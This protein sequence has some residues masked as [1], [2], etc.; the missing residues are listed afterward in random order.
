ME[1][2]LVDVLKWLFSRSDPM[3]VFCFLLLAYWVRKTN[4]K[5]DA[6]LDPNNRHP[7][8][9][10]EWGEKSYR[11][12]TVQLEKQHT[13]NRQDHQEIFGILRGK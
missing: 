7:H 12:L 1:Q 6:H 11:L 4:K 8:V 10:C 3:L 2:V 9:S 13:E 5:I